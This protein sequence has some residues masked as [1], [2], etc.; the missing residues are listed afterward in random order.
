MAMENKGFPPERISL[1]QTQDLID[2]ILSE[3]ADQ[4]GIPRG[5]REFRMRKYNR[6]VLRNDFSKRAPI[7]VNYDMLPEFLSIAGM[8][9][10]DMYEWC[11]LSLD[12]ATDEERKTCADMEKLSSG[13]LEA[14]TRLCW[15]MEPALFREE[16]SAPRPSMRVLDFR[17][18]CFDAERKKETTRRITETYSEF[19]HTIKSSRGH[20]AAMHLPT[21]FY[22]CFISV[23]D[24]PPKWAFTAPPSAPVMTANLAVDNAMD[25]Y[26]R[27]DSKNRA[28][29]NA[30]ITDAIERKGE[31]G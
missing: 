31:E 20:A 8:T 23:M 21:K 4:F 14:V 19:P 7:L 29:V 12:W 25:A 15:E 17:V 2:F 13:E 6:F 3:D 1:F 26:I 16:N 11:G 28:R 22:P 27:L 18:Y 10:K 5:E 30:V 9:Y 24:M